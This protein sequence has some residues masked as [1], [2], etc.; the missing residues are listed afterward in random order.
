MV[1]DGPVV[2]FSWSRIP[3]DNGVNTVY[4][5]FVQDFARS[6]TAADVLTTANFWALKFR[7]GGNRYDA[8]VTANLGSPSA[9]TG[10]A[11]AFIVKGA[12]PA[13]PTMVSPRHQT[14]EVTQSIAAGNLLLSWTPV[15]GATVYEYFVAVQSQPQPTVRGVTPGLFVQVPLPASA[16]VYSGIVRACP[17]GPICVPGSD[18]NWGPWSNAPGGSGVT[19]FLVQ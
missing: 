19:N 14:P 15:T 1:V 10:P 4:R 2:L 12:S 6:G 3:G 5:L 17:P 7:G 18:A 11:T 9:I 13:S 8:Q 16:T